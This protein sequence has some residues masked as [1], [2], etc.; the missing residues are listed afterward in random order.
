MKLID[1]MIVQ[2]SV[3]NAISVDQA[4]EAACLR[5]TLAV[6]ASKN[7]TPLRQNTTMRRMKLLVVLA[8]LSACHVCFSQFADDAWAVA[9]SLTLRLQP[10]A[11]S[12]LPRNIV[13]FLENR[14]Y[15]IPQ[16]CQDTSPHNVICGSFVKK[17]QQDWAVLASKKRV[18]TIMV[19]WNGSDKQPAEVEPISD[20]T[21]LQGIGGN[22]IGFSRAISVASKAFILQHYE[23]YGGPKP[24]PIDHEGIDD[25]FVEKASKVH[26]YY[27]SKWLHLTGAD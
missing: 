22:K 21:F 25:A 8:A 3:N 14:G 1:G 12:K 11:F 9:D 6:S 5:N 4:H 2:T 27:Q 17:G 26:Y 13:N 15:T 10:S 20:K 24:P 23:S 18:S 19:F 7:K 16:C